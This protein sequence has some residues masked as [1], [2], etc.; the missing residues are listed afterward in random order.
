MFEINKGRVQAIRH[1]LTPSIGYSYKP[2]FSEEFWGFYRPDPNSNFETNTSYYSIY[3]NGIFGAP[4]KG[5]QQSLNFSINNNF[6]MKMKPK[7]DSILEAKKIK[8]L[9]RLSISSSYNFA[10]D[11][12]NLSKFNI[13][14][15][16]RL[17]KN[18]SINFTS[19]IDPY[20]INGEGKR[21]KEYEWVQNRN[22]G[23]FTNAR[24]TVSSSLTSQDF[25]KDKDGEKKESEY[26]TPYDYYNYYK[27]KWSFRTNYSLNFTRSYDNE[28]EDYKTKIR[29]NMTFNININP[30]PKWSVG[31]TSGYDF[32]A[33]KVTSTTFN[34]NRDLH[35]WQMMLNI[36][37][38]GK[39][40]SY[41]FR[42][43]IKASVFE[44]VE[45]KRQKS[46]HDNF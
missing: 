5:E 32:D 42:I 9:D 28:L 1:V 44:G 36:T 16:T 12:M 34:I 33:M 25:G 27:V 3:K 8:L 11:S 29:Q 21:I 14:A 10:A 40:K 35:C 30:T 37:P 6:E 4:P 2:D 43:F 19:T 22:L 17:Y 20:A 15:G 24:F 38:F 39:M 26:L 45:Y 23:R 13:A 41:M 7:N 46:W 31:V 18:T